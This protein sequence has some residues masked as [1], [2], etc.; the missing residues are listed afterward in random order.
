MDGINLGRKEPTWSFVKFPDFDQRAEWKISGDTLTNY[1]TF[2]EKNA[3]EETDT[4]YWLRGDR[5]AQ[6]VYIKDKQVAV[7]FKLVFNVS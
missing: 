5:F 1:R 2:L 7:M 4:W 3:G 6:G